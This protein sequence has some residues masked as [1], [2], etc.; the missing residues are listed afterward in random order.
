MREGGGGGGTNKKLVEVTGGRETDTY[1]ITNH[2]GYSLGEFVNVV[3]HLLLGLSEV[4][5]LCGESHQL[6][7]HCKEQ[8]L[9]TPDANRASA[10]IHSHITMPTHKHTYRWRSYMCTSK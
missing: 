8:A 1:R 9:A 10:H 5:I 3:L 4:A 6:C 2:G 7:R